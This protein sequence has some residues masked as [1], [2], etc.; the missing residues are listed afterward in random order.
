MLSLVI[1]TM[2]KFKPFVDFIS[3]VA[4][5]SVVDDIIIINND[6]INT[7][8]HPVWSNSKIRLID[9]G[10]N[11]GVNPAWNYGV[12][13]SKNEKIIIMN[14]DVI[15][16]LKLFFKVDEFL[17]KDIGLLGLCAG[18]PE[19]NQFAIT[20]GNINFI[21]WQGEHTFGFGSLFCVHKRNWNTIPD[22]L[23][24]YYG[25]NWAFDTQLRMG[26]KNWLIVNCFFHS[27]WATTTTSTIDDAVALM[28]KET[29]IYEQAI[30]NINNGTIILH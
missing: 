12:E 10:K 27:P 29:P 2:W 9:F 11:I 17:S 19:F 3:N 8:N 25:D 20:N 13:L 6:V 26:R 21:P 18:R 16:D 15:T 22:G 5:L 7:P 14:D 30:Q 4:R 28:N 24:V 23:V 1:P